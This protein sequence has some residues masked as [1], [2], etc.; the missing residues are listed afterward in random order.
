MAYLK[1]TFYTVKLGFNNT[2]YLKYTHT[3]LHD[4]HKPIDTTL[5]IMRFTKNADNVDAIDE[6]VLLM[7]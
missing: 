5:T 6:P 2:I 3:R 1:K 7:F 4:K